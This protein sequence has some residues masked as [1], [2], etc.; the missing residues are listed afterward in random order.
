MA[1]RTANQ[2]MFQPWFIRLIIAIAIIALF[3]ICSV[4]L[5]A[6]LYFEASFGPVV[7]VCYDGA[8]SRP[9]FGAT[10]AL[11]IGLTGLVIGI[12]FD[13]AMYRFLKRRQSNTQP[14]MPMAMIAWE[15]EVP[16]VTCG[17]S[18]SGQSSKATVPI[19]ATCLGAVNLVIVVVMLF[20]LHNLNMDSKSL[21]VPI[22][23]KIGAMIVVIVHM[24]LVLVLT[25]KSHQNPKHVPVKINN[26]EFKVIPPSTLQF[27]EETSVNANA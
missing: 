11:S 4:M 24:P 14:E 15:P 17:P 13:I 23:L 25:V 16:M 5:V 12:I 1:T 18:T 26:R 21:P 3:F 2:R 8:E 20:V 27:H 7:D 6:V 19:K 22:A 9:T 10:I